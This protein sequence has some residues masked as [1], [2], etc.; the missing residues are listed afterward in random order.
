LGFVATTSIVVQVTLVLRLPVSPYLP[1]SIVAAAGS[2]PIL[3]YAVLAEYFPKEITGRA[4]GAL[5]VFHFGAAFVIQ[6]IIGVV[7]ALWPGQDGH[8]PAIAYQV[9]FGLILALQ[10]AALAWFVFSRVRTHPLVLVSAFRHRAFERAQIALIST[11]PSPQ[12]AMGWARLDADQKQMSR[13]RIAAL[14]SASLVALLGLT[15]AI[16]VVR[17]NVAPHT[18][19]TARLEEPLAALPKMEA[20]APSDPEI[21]YVLAGFV[22]NVRSLSVDPIVVR[23]NWIDALDHVTAR[24]ARM[25][26]AYARDESPFTKIGRQTVT[27]LVTKVVR[28]AREGFEIRWEER[29]LETAAP[30][31]REHF[32]GTVSILFNSSGTAKLISKNPLGLA[33]LPDTHLSYPSSNRRSRIRA[34]TNS[35]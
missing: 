28:A 35:N 26:N 13:W 24:G 9:T 6:Y 23:A 7:V 21:A 17:A 11:P 22:T 15:F 8:Y 20:A 14:G 18:V 34:P 33:R 27:V 4:N 32:T 31:R 2:G 30:L 12:P 16:S 3:S 5:N 29:I 19:A 10:A 25:L 1:W